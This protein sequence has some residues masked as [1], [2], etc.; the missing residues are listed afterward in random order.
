M[1]SYDIGALLGSGYREIR[2]KK[3]PKVL[4][5]P[6]GSELIEPDDVEPAHFTPKVTGTSSIGRRRRPLVE[7]R[8]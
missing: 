2:V 6:T 5:L 3:K 7:V 4:I 1:T 8:P